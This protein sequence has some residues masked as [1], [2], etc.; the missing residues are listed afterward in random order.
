MTKLIIK[1]V[2]SVLL[3]CV[4][5]AAAY[6]APPQEYYDSCAYEVVTLRGIF[7]PEEDDD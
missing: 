7:Q 3:A 1:Q 2:L 6:A 5:M 4:I